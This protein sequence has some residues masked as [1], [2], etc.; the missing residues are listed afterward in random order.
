[1]DA[2]AATLDRVRT[3]LK[4]Y[5]AAVL[6]AAVEGRLTEAWRVEH[7]D[8]EPAGLL[9]ERILEERCRSGT[10]FRTSN[11]TWKQG[12]PFEPFVKHRDDLPLL[13]R[14]WRWTTLGV[15]LDK[16][17]AG[18]N[19]KCLERPPAVDE[20]GVVKVSAVTWGEYDELE[21]KTCTD[22]GRIDPRSEI[23]PGD[24]LFSRA[25][26]IAL[27]GACVIVRQTSLRLMLSDKILRMRFLGVP[28]EWLLLVLRS[29]HGRNEIERLATGNQESM[30]NISQDRIR[31]IRIPMPPLDEQRQI[32]QEVDERLSIVFES[33]GQINVAMKRAAAL[34]Q[35]ILK[36][37]FEGQLVP[38]DPADEPA[39]GLLKRIRSERR[40][41][42]VTK[43]R[44]SERVGRSR[45]GRL[46]VTQPTLF[47]VE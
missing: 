38:Q 23:H 46:E 33:K 44:H 31:Q 10:D 26:T 8:V 9:L 21:S 19:F 14:G 35:S 43:N 18:K 16:I 37:A 20:V 5:Q 47:P 42:R 7:P 27:V 25:N 15:C 28:Q 12:S 2:G 30:R 4:R 3:N 6:Q 32:I 22:L 1:L 24:F 36:H 29:R 45:R 11:R 40:E 41:T 39:D 17:E 34:R 13:P